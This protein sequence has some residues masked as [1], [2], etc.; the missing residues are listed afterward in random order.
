MICRNCKY[1]ELITNS[2]LY[3]CANKNS[4]NFG[5]YTG[6]CCEDECQDGEEEH[7]SSDLDQCS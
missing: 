5:Q 7:F 6:I 3:I 2:S 4:T 1:M